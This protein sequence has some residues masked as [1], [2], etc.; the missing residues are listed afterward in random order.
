MSFREPA[1]L[2]AVLLSALLTTVTLATGATAA[3][4]AARPA[5]TSLAPYPPLVASAAA[6]PNRL[7]VGDCAEFTG[8]GLDRKSVV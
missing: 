3:P 7:T 8:G 2:V 5:L 1:R 4:L 6:T